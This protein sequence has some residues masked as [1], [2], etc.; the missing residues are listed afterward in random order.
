MLELCLLPMVL[1]LSVRALQ[2]L[3]LH[4]K[5]WIDFTLDRSNDPCH[6]IPHSFDNRSESLI[7]F[8]IKT[9]FNLDTFIDQ[10]LVIA[11]LYHP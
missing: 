2:N 8:K 10:V 6:S 7:N 11:Y 4:S 9:V 1:E 3:L 5:C